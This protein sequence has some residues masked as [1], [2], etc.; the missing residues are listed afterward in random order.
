MTEEILL[1]DDE[2]GIREVLGISLSDLGY[3]IHTAESG[4]QA[5]DM[6]REIRPPVV[7]TDIKMPGMDGLTL[8]KKIKEEVPDTEVIVLTGQGDMDLAIKSLKYEATD[9]ITKPI[10]DEALEI[11]LRRA[12]EKIFMRQQLR[13]YTE[14]L[15]NLVE[16]KS[17]ELIESERMAAVGQ[18]IAGL[19]H[20]IKNI[21][22]GLEGGVFVLEKGIELDEKKYI[23]EGWEM[24]KHS[25]EK[26]KNL[27]MG[28]LQFARSPRDN[29]RL[30]D[31]VEPL[32]EVAEL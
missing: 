4:E 2:Q 1:V 27:S 24:L 12:R 22:G 20:A 14:N 9:F 31:P 18:T 8:L 10:S 3:K 23:N 26:I 6:F 32:R 7:I 13:E 17:R 30:C 11:A 5:L 28:L 25:V 29:G 21:S 19:S 15:E 16:Q